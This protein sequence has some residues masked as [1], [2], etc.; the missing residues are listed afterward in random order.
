M[1]D[2]REN[3][4]KTALGLFVTNGFHATPTSKIAKEAGVATGTLFH[5]FKTKDELIN[6][7]YLD[8]KEKMIEAL[9]YDLE[10][11]TSFKLNFKQLY[12]NTIHWSVNNQNEFLFFQ[13]FSNSP[14][15]SDETKL[16]GSERFSFFKELLEK[17]KK[18]EIIKNIDNDIMMGILFG[19]IMGAMQVFINI[20]DNEEIKNTKELSFKMIWDMIKE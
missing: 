10:K 16:Q 13:M 7:L 14:Y 3:I 6:C 15:I 5:H 11:T 18:E 12:F 1:V 8:S 4:L 17:G 19:A 2:K 20:S 9:K